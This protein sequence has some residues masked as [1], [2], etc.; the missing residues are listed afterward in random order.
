MRARWISSKS[1]SSTSAKPASRPAAERRKVGE[2]VG[3]FINGD[4]A[5]EFPRAGAAHAV[6]DGKDE[7]DLASGVFTD[8]AHVADLLGVEL[9]AEE[10][11]L[12]VLADL[13]AVGEA[14]PQEFSAA[15]I[16]RGSLTDR[17]PRR[18]WWRI[19]NR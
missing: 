17:P 10:G 12:V 11:V 2:Q 18:G 4:A 3:D 19:Q 15:L 14:I 1:S 5:G 8:A 7:I 16:A 13:A 6:A 9:E